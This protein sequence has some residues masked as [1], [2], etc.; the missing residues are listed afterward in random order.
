MSALLTA[1][2]AAEIIGVDH[3]IVRVWM[4]RRHHPLPSVPIG[5]TGTQRRVVASMIDDWLAAEVAREQ[6]TDEQSPRTYRA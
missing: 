1:T 5:K 3:H 4:Y 2:E 6:P